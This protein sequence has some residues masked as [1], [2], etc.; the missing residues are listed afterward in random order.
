MNVLM[1]W[2][3]PANAAE[4]SIIARR[5][6]PLLRH[7]AAEGVR[8]T[9]VLFGDEGR[10]RDDF[11]AAGIAVE[12]LPTPLPPSAA[13]LRNLPAAAIRLRPLI[14]ALQPDV[15]E[16]TEPMPAIALGLAAR[17]SRGNGVVTYRRQHSGGGSMRL[18]VASWL[19]A[20]LAQ[21]TVVLSEATRRAAAADDGT[22]LERIELARSGA[23]PPRAVSL[24]E[25]AAV[26]RSLGIGDGAFVIG[27]VSRFRRE[28]GVDVLLCALASLRDLA[29]VHVVLAGNG[30]EEERLRE[31]A[32]RA[33][34]PVHFVGHRDDIEIWYALSDVI[35][36]PSRRESFSRVAVE[37]MASGRP[38]VATRVGGLVEA[39]VEGETGLLVPPDD[40]EAM[41]AALRTILV[42]RELA[43]RM[44]V[45]ARERYETRH[46]IA[47]M[48]AAR[49]QAWERALA[50]ANAK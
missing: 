31:L 9:L 33:A 40:P 23:A 17:S 42:D 47:H 43:G 29:D 6:V 48:A 11:E 3:G 45:A 14:R 30:P 7:L 50:G 39:V 32:A 28:K 13:A 20:R 5:E 27:V 46:T 4:R 34:F 24:E 15:M 19:A 21:R 10:M 16:G 18:Q 49:R 36:M 35:A 25:I 1:A 2:N 41:A 8:T 37:V 12:V 38:L 44:R 22:P 26:R